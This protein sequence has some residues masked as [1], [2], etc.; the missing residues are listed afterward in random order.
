MDQLTKD[1]MRR[2]LL[3]V[4]REYEEQGYKVLLEPRGAELPEFLSQFS[5]DLIAYS[6]TENVVVAVKSRSTLVG[7]S[8]F[9]ALTDVVNARPG[10]RLDLDVTN[11]Q[12]G[13][14]ASESSATMSPLPPEVWNS[15]VAR[16]VQLGLPP[17]D[18]LRLLV[19][20]FLRG[21][22]ATFRET[23]DHI[24]T[25]YEDLLRRLA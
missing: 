17:H 7:S 9:L 24:F 12:N 13:Q 20:D 14:T 10:W 3:E 18:L 8:D 22:D 11:P 25:Q 2:R 19:E 21:P 6:D 15:F 23:S 1:L 16:A 5:P 4:K